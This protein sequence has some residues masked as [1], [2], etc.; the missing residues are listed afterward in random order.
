MVAK[1]AD[2]FSLAQILGYV[3]LL[4]TVAGYQVAS[5]RHTLLIHVCAEWAFSLHC[6]LMGAPTAA[7]Q[8]A[9]SGFRNLALGLV[10]HRWS[11]PICGA[12]LG[13][14]YVNAALAPGQ[15]IDILPA[16]GTTFGT[17][18]AFF[19]DRPTTFRALSLACACTWLIFCA[20]IASVGG[21]I[22]ATMTLASILL[23]MFRFRHVRT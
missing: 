22:E 4:I 14:A 5:P 23:A 2:L 16:I 21:T 9:G 3:G 19:R 6:W 1:L 18:A 8:T 12:Y 10:P 15:A 13:F 7:A 20:L 11:T 17:A